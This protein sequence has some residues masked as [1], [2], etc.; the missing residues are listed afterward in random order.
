MNFTDSEGQ[1]LSLLNPYILCGP[2]TN[3]FDAASVYRI[4]ALYTQNSDNGE[5]VTGLRLIRQK[6]ETNTTA[7]LESINNG[8][9]MGWIII[10]D[11]P[12]SVDIADVKTDSPLQVEV[13]GGRI[14]V[15]GTDR[16]AVYGLNGTQ[17]PA[18]TPLPQGLYIVKAGN[19]TV[20]VLVP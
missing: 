5:A 1:T 2:Q 6:D 13:S 14:I 11:D 16:Y 8:D 19:R 10:S 18:D 9:Y 7:G 4:S 17:M 3:N 20:K 15:K 12:N